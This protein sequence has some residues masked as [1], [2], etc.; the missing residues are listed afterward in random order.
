VTAPLGEVGRPGERA[1]SFGAEAVEC[2]VLVIGGRVAGSILATA[3]AAEG[4]DVV[5]VDRARFPSPTVSTHFFRG[6]RGVTALRDLG[7]LDDVLALGPPKLTCQYDYVGAADPEINPPQDAGEPGFCLSVRREPLDDI[8]LRRAQREPTVRVF[9]E[10]RLLELAWNG[11]RV[12]GAMLERAG[13]RLEVKARFT[14][15]ADGRHSTV[16]RQVSPQLEHSDTP[17]RAL[18]YRYVRDFQPPGTD[19]GPEFSFQ[20]DEVAY[21]FPSDDGVTCL[22]ASINLDT[23]RAIRRSLNTSFD[24][25]IARHPGIIERY[26]RATPISKILGCGPEPSYVRRP[27]GDGWALVGDASIHQDPWTGLGIDFASTHALWLAEA[28]STA[29][30]DR[31]SETTALRSY[32]KR[33]NEQDIATYR[34]TTEL[35]KDLS[36]A[37]SD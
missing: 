28:L 26:Q 33:R 13:E 21:V 24:E 8:L 1:A 36:K 2:D 11:G 10:T 17:T 16:A 7:V 4:H 27:F 37:G 5:V 14:V 6:A 25:V 18:F 22:A 35:A 15:G 3:L 19:P 9:Q 23:F 20:G 34:Q 12:T 32:W 31:K 30:S 29:L